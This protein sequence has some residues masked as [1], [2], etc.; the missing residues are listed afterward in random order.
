MVGQAATI[1][2]GNQILLQTMMAGPLVAPAALFMKPHPQAPA[3]HEHI[4]DAH[5]QGRTDPRERIYHQANQ[6]PIAQ[7]GRRRHVDRIEQAARL[8]WIR[9][10]RLAAPDAVRRPPHQYGR[11]YRHH[12]TGHQP[13][14]EM[15]DAAQALLDGRRRYVAAELLDSGN[16]VQRLHPR[17]RGKAT[18][19]APPQNSPQPRA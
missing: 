13:V 17:D 19:S 7:A 5:R 8:A 11:I 2:I 18:A 1:T 3:L 12:L 10:G 14:K 9:H 15:A 4:F 16:H 6:R